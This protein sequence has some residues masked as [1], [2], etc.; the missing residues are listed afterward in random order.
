MANGRGD[1]GDASCRGEEC[2]QK[3][4]PRCSWARDEEWS[5]RGRER[6]TGE[7]RERRN[8]GS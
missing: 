5:E 4:V 3:V 7:T 8:G 6:L 1:P 2:G